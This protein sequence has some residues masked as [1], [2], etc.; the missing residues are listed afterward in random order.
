[1]IHEAES[2]LS[3]VLDSLVSLPNVDA[4]SIFVSFNQKGRQC[5]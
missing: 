2:L 3:S 5:S 1:M 4:I